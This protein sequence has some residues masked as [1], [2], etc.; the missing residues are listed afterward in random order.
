QEE[1]ELEEFYR[2]EEDFSEPSQFWGYSETQE[3]STEKL[4]FESSFHEDKL[5]PEY[6]DES[7]EGFENFETDEVLNDGFLKKFTRFTSSHKYLLCFIPLIFLV[8][9]LA[10]ASTSHYGR[11]KK[12][13]FTY[14]GNIKNSIPNG[15]G[16]IAYSNG[17]SYKGNFVDGKFSGKGT[18]TS[19]SG[20]WSYTGNFTNGL[21]NGTGLMTTADGQKHNETFKNGALSQ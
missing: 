6:S 4:T 11:I 1:A 5:K 18:F 15:T 10:T 12:T 20:K 17:D 9:F 2:N 7:I 21:P 16:A 14:L 13:D 3:D 19:K 8:L